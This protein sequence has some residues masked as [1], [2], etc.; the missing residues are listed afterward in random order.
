MTSTF[1]RLINARAGQL[2]GAVAL[3]FEPEGVRCELSL[4]LAL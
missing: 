2:G 3:R 4:P 1:T